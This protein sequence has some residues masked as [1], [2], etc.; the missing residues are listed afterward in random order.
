MSPHLVIDRSAVRAFCQR[1]RIGRLALFGSALRDD[2]GLDSDV[3]V[4]VEFEP[5]HVPG[6]DFVSIEREL[7]GL[8]QG[9]RVDLVTPKFLNVRIRE[10]VLREAEPLYVAA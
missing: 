4:L 2:F 7:S 8:L 1:H 9:R 6:L 5:G 3:D 10:Q